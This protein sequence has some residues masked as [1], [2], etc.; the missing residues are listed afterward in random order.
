M[1]KSGL[2]SGILK[3]G[4]VIFALAVLFVFITERG[5]SEFVKYW[6]F[7][8]N[9]KRIHLA[10]LFYAQKHD[11]LMPAASSWADLIKDENQLLL[12]NDFITPMSYPDF[13][14]YYNTALDNQSLPSLKDDTVV[15]FTGEGAWNSNGNR[16][17]FQKQAVHR[18]VYVITL[19]GEIYRYNHH[20]D[21]YLRLKDSQEV[22]ADRLYWE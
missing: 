10:V 20:N 12:K 5:R 3:T 16:S 19:K 18:H 15:L 22:H 4:L 17:S 14:I 2:L 11:G 8:T 21:T 9:L 7:K 6:Y 13:G 1:K